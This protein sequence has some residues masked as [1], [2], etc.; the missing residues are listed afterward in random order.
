MVFGCAGLPVLAA[1]II[2]SAPLPS[3]AALRKTQLA[4]SSNSLA[5][6]GL[7]LATRLTATEASSARLRRS[8]DPPPAA[9]S[10]DA[11]ASAGAAVRSTLAPPALLL[12]SSP[13]EG[14]V[15][16]T[17]LEDFVSIDQVVRP[18]ID[19]GLTAPHGIFYDPGTGILLVADV[20]SRKVFRYVIG[21]QGAGSVQGKGRYKIVVR[22]PQHTLV[23]DV[24]A[25]WV[26][27]DTAGNVYYTNEDNG[28]SINRLDAL[29]IKKLL[30]GYVK[31]EDLRRASEFET[32]HSIQEGIAGR[33]YATF[34]LYGAEQGG[35][36]RRPAGL[37]LD[38]EH[39][40]W[41]TSDQGDNIVWATSDQGASGDSL[42][43]APLR[44]PSSSPSGTAPS[45]S[46]GAL[47][48]PA[49]KSLAKGT[50]PACEV[51]LANT[52]IV[53]SVQDHNVY[54]ICNGAEQTVQLSSAFTAP[55]GLAWDGDNTL[56]VADTNSSSVFSL[57][58]GRC[59]AGLVHRHVVNFHGVFSL[60]L[61]KSTDPSLA[62]VLG[63]EN[64]HDTSDSSEGWFGGLFG[65]S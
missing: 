58:T 19:A 31:A 10:Q 25:R 35:S 62:E 53:Y 42:V 15:S 40:L 28:G 9:F 43:V 41:A 13:A 6:H 30:A 14:K 33:S 8:R 23:Q 52:M 51:A 49:P 57:P 21:V 27:M 45:S 22:E 54:G 55:R 26:T 2:V 4:A 38:G 29:V 64:Q 37:V 20:G 18:L 59:H 56:Y 47:L 5:T 16:Y 44:P 11:G 61:I 34:P 17:Q 7:A 1:A 65:S 24:G 32:A 39:I 3:L 48:M 12:M 36:M 50:G 60:A 46:E 63:G